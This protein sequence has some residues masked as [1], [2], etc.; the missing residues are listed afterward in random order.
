M[1]SLT[2]FKIGYGPVGTARAM[3]GKVALL[4]IE[5]I[6]YSQEFLISL[7]RFT[8][9]LPHMTMM[10]VIMITRRVALKSI[11]W[12]TILGPIFIFEPGKYPINDPNNTPNG[13]H[14]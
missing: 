11:F 5:L 12:I 3:H 14:P 8:L 4:H 13:D 1:P 10:T 6:P 9:Q 7:D 2:G